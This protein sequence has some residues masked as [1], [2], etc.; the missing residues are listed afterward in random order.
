MTATDHAGP[1]EGVAQDIEAP[2]AEQAAVGP[3]TGDP[4]IVGVPTFVV[5]SVMLGLALIN[6]APAAGGALPIIIVATGIGQLLATVWSAALGQSAVAAVFAVFGGFWLSYAALLT[7][8][9]HGWWG[10][11]PAATSHTVAAFLISWIV[12]I[13]VL[14]AASLRLPSA[15]TLIFVLVEVALILVLAGTVNGSSGLDKA[16]GIVV[17]AF[18]AVG[19]YVFAG[20]LSVATGGRPFP[21]GRPVIT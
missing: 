4:A 8:L 20:S 18:A 2:V 15:F 9:A 17:F 6:Y 1:P 12:I 13:A 10:V 19:A 5:G 21:L 3:L 7:G 11:T 14:T 16:A